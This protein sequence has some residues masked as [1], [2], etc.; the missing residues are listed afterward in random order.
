M[1]IDRTRS[2][3]GALA[4]AAAAGVWLVQQPLDQR[5]FG[6]D[7]DDADLL[8]RFVTSGR[9]VLPAG[10]ALHLANGAL[11]GAAYA[12]AAPGMPVPPALRGPLAGL[13][14]HLATWPL[15]VLLDRVHR[16][17][18]GLPPL[19]GSG[20]AFA[21]ATWRHVLFGAVLGA[22]ER[23]LNQPAEPAGVDPAAVASNGHG[24]AEHLVASGPAQ[25]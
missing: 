25:Y 19:W 8:G 10:V 9:G 18:G 11:F 17:S 6:V 13:A 1:P 3:R 15:T 4:G 5:V 21:Q 2:L 23:R 20:R 22:L 14:E 16:A 24:S 7:Y 12:A